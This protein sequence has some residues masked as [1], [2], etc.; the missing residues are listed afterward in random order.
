MKVTAVRAALHC[1]FCHEN[2][3]IEVTLTLDPDLQGEPIIN[4]DRE[5]AAELCKGH[6]GPMV[7]NVAAI[8]SADE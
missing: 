1:A 8:A 2:M 7:M 4:W 6:V 3:P 5:L